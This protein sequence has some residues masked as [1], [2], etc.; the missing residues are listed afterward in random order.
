MY[1]LKSF[2]NSWA[3]KAKPN[4]EKFISNWIKS[5]EPGK[6][7]LDAGA[8]EQKH[9]KYANHLKYTSQDFGEY[10]GGD[11]IEC[12]KKRGDWKSSNCDIISDIVDIPVDD[13]SFDHVICSE[14]FEHLPDPISA[15]IEIKRVLK[16]GGT[17]ALT[18]P[19]RCIYHQE[20]YFFNS[21]FSTYWY[22]YHAN[23]LQLEILSIEPNGNY[24]VEIANEVTRVWRFGNGLI[25][26]ISKI[27][28]VQFLLLLF[29]FDKFTKANPPKNCWGYHVVLRKK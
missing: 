27:I 2:L 1:T 5:I 15:L 26:F 28:C 8:G 4:R 24:F 20:P 11:Y 19:F 18:V 17:I 21:G 13:E 25:R 12:D 10:K 22:E 16:K 9:K 14:V 29:Y 3:Y 23:K 6:K 7:L